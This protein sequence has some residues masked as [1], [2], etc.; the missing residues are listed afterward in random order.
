MT[1]E[2]VNPPAAKISPGTTYRHAD[3]MQIGDSI[4]ERNRQRMVAI[5]ASVLDEVIEE[6]RIEIEIILSRDDLPGTDYKK[7]QVAHWESVI[8]V[9]AWLKST[10]FRQSR[11]R[12]R[13]PELKGK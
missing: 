7:N 6:A 11:T 8:K 2:P 3:K 5:V 1:D 13:P 10:R 4:N 9:C 12:H